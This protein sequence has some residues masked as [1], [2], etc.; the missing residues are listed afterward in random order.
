MKTGGAL[1]QMQGYFSSIGDNTANRWA[2]F[3][4]IISGHRHRSNLVGDA[5]NRFGDKIY[6]RLRKMHLGNRLQPARV[7]ICHAVMGQM[8]PQD[9]DSEFNEWDFGTCR[10][11][12]E[13]V[14][15]EWFER[16]NK[17]MSDVILK[18][19]KESGR[20][21]SSKT[22]HEALR[23]LP[24]ENQI[25]IKDCKKTV[26]SVLPQ[27]HDINECLLRIAGPEK[28]WTI[29]LNLAR[30][31]RESGAGFIEDDPMDLLVLNEGRWRSEIREPGEDEW[32]Q[33]W[34]KS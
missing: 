3:L 8:W 23:L 2:D 24:E 25:P 21:L 33:M 26:W 32:F 7:T 27:S 19:L 6:Y 22:A 11:T 4:R 12:N 28:M 17:R 5:K 16:N 15:A 14:E 10:R 34:H 20:Y 31:P 1:I 9:P 13:D 18:I 29:L 30:R